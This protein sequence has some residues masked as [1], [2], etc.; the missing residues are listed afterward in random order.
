MMIII[1]IIMISYKKCVEK[2]KYEE[3]YILLQRRIYKIFLTGPI[4]VDVS[5]TSEMFL[6]YRKYFALLFFV[7]NKLHFLSQ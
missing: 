3:L 4:N 5:Q 1:I 6:L 7:L 2:L